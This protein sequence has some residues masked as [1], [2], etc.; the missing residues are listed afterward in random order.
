MKGSWSRRREPGRQVRILLVWPSLLFFGS[1]WAAPTPARDAYDDDRRPEGRAEK[2]NDRAEEQDDTPSAGGLKAPES[3]PRQGEEA[4]EIEKELKRS[5][6]RD[7]QRG[8]EFAWLEAT[9]GYQWVSLDG[10]VARDFVPDV[11]STERSMFAWSVAGGVR[12][13]YFTLGAR[14]RNSNTPLYHFWTLAG[15]AALRV[16]LGAWEP[17][18]GVG[19]GAAKVGKLQ[20][21]GERFDEGRGELTRIHGLTTRLFGGMDYYFSDSFSVGA[22]FTGDLLFL[23]RPEQSDKL[24]TDANDCVYSERGR[25]TGLSV[26]TSVEL[27][28]HF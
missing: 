1:C 3:L 10:L 21:R 25:S 8:L 16:P 27:G 23:A 26:T 17:Y 4:S 5:D 2:Q 9:L 15:E 12:L 18:G 6:E 11:E 14:F 20:V 22:N 13:L 24:C 28:L 7:A 19:L